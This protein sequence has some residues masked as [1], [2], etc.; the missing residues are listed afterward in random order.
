MFL[1][2][3]SQ[4]AEFISKAL[5]RRD[6]GIPSN[7]SSTIVSLV[8]PPTSSSVKVTSVVGSVE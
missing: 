6:A 3:P 7:P 4:P 2:C 8:P 1:T 5:A